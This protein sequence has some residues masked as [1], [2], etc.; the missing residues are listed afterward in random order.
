M[1][2][3]TT[4]DTRPRRYTMRDQKGNPVGTGAEL[5]AVPVYAIKIDSAYQRDVKAAWVHAH[6][7]FDPKTAGALIL[8]SRAGGPYCIDGQHRLALARESGTDKVHALVIDGLTQADEARLFVIYQRSRTNLTSH[9]LFR[10]ELNAGDPETT[11]M[12]R[13]VNNAGFHLAKKSGPLNITAIDAVR[14]VMRYGGDD[15]LARTLDLIRRLWFEEE[16]ALSGQIIKGIALFLSSA[17][18]QPT[19]SRERLERV[20]KANGPL[21][22]M[23]IA[24]A[25]AEKRKAA[26]SS[27]ANIAEALQAEYNKLV[28]KG[29]EPLE[30]LRIGEKR[31]PV[32]RGTRAAA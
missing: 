31:R 15:L 21:R 8:S 30:P 11:A 23:R 28:T 17:G 1:T 4:G 16:K 25:I 3:P 12:V 2:M 19:F 9:A 6:M 18:E 10:A 5:R 26:T 29:E 14:W 13:I 22:I 20:M 7:P 27:P 32:A 24:Q